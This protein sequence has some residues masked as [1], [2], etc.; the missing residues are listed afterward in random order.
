[1]SKDEHSFRDVEKLQ[2]RENT[3][4]LKASTLVNKMSAFGN[5]HKEKKESIPG[6]TNL[7]VNDRKVME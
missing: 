2:G 6:L 7:R 4:G 3:D 1:M 5:N